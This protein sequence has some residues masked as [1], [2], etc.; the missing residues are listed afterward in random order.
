M[1]D[2]TTLTEENIL[3]ILF[4]SAALTKLANQHHVSVMTISRIQRGITWSHCHPEIARRD[5]RHPYSRA[6]RNNDVTSA[7]SEAEKPGNTL[8]KED[9]ESI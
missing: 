5:F 7:A 4:S 3:G 8:Y 2:L 9:N 6:C 1:R